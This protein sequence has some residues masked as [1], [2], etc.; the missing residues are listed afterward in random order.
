[1]LK[2]KKRKKK[3]KEEHMISF[4][5]ILIKDLIPEKLMNRQQLYTIAMRPNQG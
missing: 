4:G 3:R 5:Q 1:M 2:K